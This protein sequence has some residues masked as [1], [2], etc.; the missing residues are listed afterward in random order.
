MLSD[1]IKE[2]AEKEYTVILDTSAIRDIN[3][4][5]LTRVFRSQ[6]F[7]SIDERD[8]DGL[9]NHD[10][11]DVMSLE[12]VIVIEE[13]MRERSRLIRAVNSRYKT[14]RNMEIL[15][16]QP[17]RRQNRRNYNKR[18]SRRTSKAGVKNFP[19][20]MQQSLYEDFINDTK[21]IQHV[22]GNSLPLI[23][24]R[25]LHN[26]VREFMIELVNAYGLKKTPTRQGRYEY[27]DANADE[28]LF[29]L[30]LYYAG[31]EKSPST[32]V[33][34]D[35]DIGRIASVAINYL[36]NASP[37]DQDLQQTLRETPLTVVTLNK[38]LRPAQTLRTDYT[39]PVYEQERLQE[40]FDANT[41]LRRMAIEIRKG[42]SEMHYAK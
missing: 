38:N 34:A 3:I 29:A 40:K 21:R 27:P 23:K 10:L 15:A 2:I 25:V 12:N 28:S 20:S 22:I 7:Q 1:T 19:K 39:A 32:I 31:G 14:W 8:F 33:T 35:R 24:N 5:K 13:V 9:F 4:P 17:A 36:L 42:L 11:V 26:E 37:N 16:S 6:R 41:E 30:A 18:T